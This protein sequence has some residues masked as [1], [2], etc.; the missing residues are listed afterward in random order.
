[1]YITVVGAGFSG[2]HRGG[3]NG[4]MDTA[5][6]EDLTQAFHQLMPFTG[7]LGITVVRYSPEEVVARLPWRP[8]LCTSGDA[9]HGGAIM[10]LADSTGGACAYLN[11]P[12]GATGTTTI[13]SKTNFLRAVREGEAAARSRPLHL[14]R[15]VLVIETEVTDGRDRPVARVVQSQLVL[16]PR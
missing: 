7:T 10:A 14:G 9:L 2:I 5:P 11:L 3:H 16:T 12:D 4:A 6:G 1:M 15:T 13:E 8:E